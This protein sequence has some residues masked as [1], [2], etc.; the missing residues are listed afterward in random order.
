MTVR[1]SASTSFTAE[2]VEALDTVLATILRGGSVQTMARHPSVIAVMR[3]VSRMKERL[4]HLQRLRDNTESA[5]RVRAPC[6]CAG[7]TIE[8]SASNPHGHQP[9]CPRW[10]TDL[11]V[12]ET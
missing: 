11:P 8:A 1:V 5:A 6:T 12:D 2:E 10:E 7:D 9:G 3:K 4:R